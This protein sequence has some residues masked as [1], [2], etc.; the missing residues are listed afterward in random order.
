MKDDLTFPEEK[1]YKG[2]NKPL[3]SEFEEISRKDRSSHFK[4]QEVRIF[5]ININNLYF[6]N[7][8][9]PSA[10]LLI[11]AAFISLFAKHWHCAGVGTMPWEF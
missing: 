5:R 3:F 1:Q 4:L 2:S 8:A 6:V 7:V 11:L 10:Q 9:L